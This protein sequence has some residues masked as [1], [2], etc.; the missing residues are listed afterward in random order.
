MRTGA[1]LLVQ[2]RVVAQAPIA[3]IEAIVKA[4]EVIVGSLVVLVVAVAVMSA[5]KVIVN[6]A[7][8]DAA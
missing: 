8:I 2:R 4:Q 1:R 7:G 6:K 5:A 3:N